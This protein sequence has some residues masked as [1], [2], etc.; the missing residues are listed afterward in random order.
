VVRVNE[1]GVFMLS[2]EDKWVKAKR[3]LQEVLDLIKTDP[4]LI[5]RK[6]LEQVRGFLIYVTRIYPCMVPY[7]IG[8]H[9]TIDGRRQ[10]RDQ[11]GWRL[12]T[13]DLRLRAAAAALLDD[14]GLDDECC[15]FGGPKTRRQ[16]AGY[17]N[18]D[19]KRVASPSANTV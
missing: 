9:M 8:M 7:L 17:S 19:D 4:A 13:G 12:S 14:E 6:R 16:H 10:G 15:H 3:L 11:E 2:D 1:D 18:A 5:L